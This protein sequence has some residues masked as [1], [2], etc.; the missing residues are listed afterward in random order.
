MGLRSSRFIGLWRDRKNAKLEEYVNNVKVGSWSTGAPN[1]TITS[2]LTVSAGSVALPA[3]TIGAADIADD[4]LTGDQVADV[5]DVNTEGGVLLVYRIDVPAVSATALSANT[6]ITVVD[7]IR[8]VDYIIIKTAGTTGGG[9]ENISILSTG[10]V[11]GEVH[12][13]T[14]ADKAVLRPT[15]LDDAQL[16]IGA[17]EILRV[18]VDTSITDETSDTG[19]AIITAMKIA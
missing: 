2:G 17:G 19:L 9:A 3:G 15:T 11:I 4:S 10:A 5:A 8:I 14:G 12:S 13:W 1:L 16:T 7:K 18:T 6:D